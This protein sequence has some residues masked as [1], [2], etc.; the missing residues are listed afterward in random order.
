MWG[1][2]QFSPRREVQL[3]WADDGF[4][5][6]EEWPS[7]LRAYTFGIYVHAGVWK[8]QVVQDPYPQRIKEVVDEAVVR[9]MTANILVNGQNF[10]PFIFNLEAYARAAWAPERFDAD[11]FYLEWTSR[12]F[13]EAASS[14]SVE[15]LKLLH[16]AHDYS[17]GFREVTKASEKIL[18]N[19]NQRSFEMEEI[20]DVRTSLALVR[21][22]LELAEQAESLVPQSALDVFD[23]QVL[24]P[25]R[26]YGE[27]LEL[28]KSLIDFNNAYVAN[29][30]NR[31]SK[32]KAFV[33]TSG[34]FAREQLL[35]L[36]ATLERGS[37][38]KKWKNWTHPDNFR[39]HTPPPKLEDIDSIIQAL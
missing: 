9:G 7:R 6:F 39:I 34:L 36:R 18:K 38:W 14:L 28:L 13:G 33:R 12:Y 37:R 32:A 17:I 24:F 8:N 26:L 19:L 10:K 25:C 2:G 5:K 4:A 1:N 23:D 3:L 15:S 22:S 27:N 29:R 11:A 16:Q 30:G 35:N 31:S 20:T 21:K